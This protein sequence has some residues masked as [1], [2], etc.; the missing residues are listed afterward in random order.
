MADHRSFRAPHSS[1]S[2]SPTALRAGG[3]QPVVDE[4]RRPLTRRALEAA[5][6]TDEGAAEAESDRPRA[7]IAGINL[8]DVPVAT[9]QDELDELTS[10]LATL[11]IDVVSV[12]IQKRE[13]PDAK[14]L[15]GTGKIEEIKQL[16]EDLRA[17]VLVCDRMLSPPQVRNIQKLTGLEVL[18]RPGVI[19]EIFSEHAQTNEAKTQVEIARL[20]YLLPRLQGAWTHFQKQRGGGSRQRGMGEKQIEVDRRMARARITKLAK[21]LEGIRNEKKLQRKKRQELHRVA[22][23]GYTNSGKTTIMKKLTDSSVGPENKLFA[24]LDTRIKKI[25]GDNPPAILLSDTVGFIRNLPHGLVESFLSTLDEVLEADVL[26]QVVDIHAD[27]EMQIAVTREVLSEIGADGIP[28]LYVFNKCDLLADP[29]LP[30]IL[31]KS[32]PGSLFISSLGDDKLEE[33]QERIVALVGKNFVRYEL[34][35]PISDQ[36]M[37]SIV[38]KSCKIIDTEYRDDGMVAYS[39]KSSRAV[40]QK[41]QAL[42][43]AN[44]SLN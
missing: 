27:Y 32:F 12:V 44:K 29:F 5:A 8:P 11:G 17:D 28:V 7:I 20:E 38:Y 33:L 37:Q 1:H 10:L 23:V 21:Q 36:K 19:L 35:M 15:L 41:L 25:R 31:K 24:T 6:A 42:A 22:L 13:R 9:S 40:Y 30:K 14:T 3:D 2:A 43:A 39:L 4:P 34:T 16:A 26:V 18:D